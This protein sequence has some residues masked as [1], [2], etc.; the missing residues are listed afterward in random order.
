MIAGGGAARGGGGEDGGTGYTGG[1][2][3]AG[4]VTLTYTTADVPAVNV[5]RFVLD[6]PAG[7]GASGASDP[8]RT[9]K[10]AGCG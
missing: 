3:A 8:S 2:G 9:K 5:F 10:R 6:V 7:G 1:N 4:K